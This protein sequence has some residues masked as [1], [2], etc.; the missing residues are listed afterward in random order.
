VDD[1]GQVTKKAEDKLTE[2]V[3]AA[4]QEQQ[5]LLATVNPTKV[6]G[7]GVGAPAKR[8]EGEGGDADD[9]KPGEGTLWGAVLQE[10]GVDPAKAWDD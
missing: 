3:A 2:S 5:D 1:D 8:G 6:R 4:I 7:Q 10:A 9:S